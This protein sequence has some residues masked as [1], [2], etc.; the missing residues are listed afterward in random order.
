MTNFNQE[1]TH[2]LNMYRKG[3]SFEFK[4]SKENFNFMETW[5]EKPTDTEMQNG[6][7]ITE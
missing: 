4:V 6:I 5:F 7:I 3:T 1:K 2:T